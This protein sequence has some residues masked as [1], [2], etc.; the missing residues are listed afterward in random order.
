MSSSGEPEK[1]GPAC[2]GSECVAKTT[3]PEV[4]S[5]TTVDHTV[6]SKLERILA[7]NITL[8]PFTPLTPLTPDLKINPEDEVEIAKVKKLIVDHVHTAADVLENFLNSFATDPAFHTTEA[9]KMSMEFCNQLEGWLVAFRAYDRDR[10]EYPGWTCY[11]HE[12]VLDDLTLFEFRSFGFDRECAYKLKCTMWDYIWRTHEANDVC[13]DWDDGEDEKN[14]VIRTMNVMRDAIAHLCDRL[15]YYI[16]HRL[17]DKP[18]PK[19]PS[20]D[21]SDDPDTYG[22]SDGEDEDESEDESE[23]EHKDESED[24]DRIHIWSPP[25][26]ESLKKIRIPRWEFNRS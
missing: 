24:C 20:Y 26:E 5:S 13:E 14:P 9:Y 8:A 17:Y 22:H 4:E 6:K 21:P 12:E 15:V 3:Q 11:T 1:V 2:D 25:T 10:Q 23:D 7:E 19:P 16:E 18:K